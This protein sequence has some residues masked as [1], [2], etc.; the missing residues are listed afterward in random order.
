MVRESAMESAATG[1]EF[2]DTQAERWIGL[3][4]IKP[5]FRDRLHLFADTLARLQPPPARVIDFGC[6]PGVISMELAA[7]GYEV[8]GVDGAP[9]MIELARAEA[10]RRGLTGARFEVATADRFAVADASFDAAVCSSVIE[11]VE[12]DGRL[13]ADLARAIRPGGHLLISVP[14]V[15]SMQGLVE[16]AVSRLP[17]YRSAERRRHLSFSLRRY[18]RREFADRLARAGFGSFGFTTFETAIPGRIGVALSRW[19][20]VGVML[21]VSAR[22][23]S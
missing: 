20:R 12:D 16:E 15:D 9:K 17:T 21:L 4:A 23:V 18:R 1:T 11:Y 7:R 3:Y 13:I 8:T 2:F 6:G 22:R 19:R 14:H 5:S 10:Q